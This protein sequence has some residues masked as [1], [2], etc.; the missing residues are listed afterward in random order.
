MPAK[1]QTELT[2][3]QLT[4]WGNATKAA[5][6]EQIQQAEQDAAGGKITTDEMMN[7]I[8]QCRSQIDALNNAAN[9][10]ASYSE[11]A[12]SQGAGD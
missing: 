11:L 2:V 10:L 6:E 9:S 12:F 5:L 1:D 4:A 3:A 8:S 7:T